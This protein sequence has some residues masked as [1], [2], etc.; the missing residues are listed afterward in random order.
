MHTIEITEKT[1]YNLAINANLEMG[2][3]EIE[4]R[5]NGNISSIGRPKLSD[6][7]TLSYILTD[8]IHEPIGDGTVS[9]LTGYSFITNV[10]V[11]TKLVD[12]NQIVTNAIIPK[13]DFPQSVILDNVPLWDTDD[14][15]DPN[16]GQQEV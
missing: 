7:Q 3:V 5:K 10:R 12:T 15:V 4:L 2:T 14:T 13:A 16:I 6:L 1:W 8:A 11:Y 9:F